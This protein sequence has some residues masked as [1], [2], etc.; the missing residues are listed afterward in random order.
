MAETTSQRLN[1]EREIALREGK[2]KY[3]ESY[4]EFPLLLPDQPERSKREDFYQK[5]AKEYLSDF[6][7]WETSPSEKISI[8]CF[9]SWLDR[10]CGTLNTVETQ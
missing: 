3:N 8:E 4:D 10:R 7:E 6:E 5:L 9:A 2:I 1:P